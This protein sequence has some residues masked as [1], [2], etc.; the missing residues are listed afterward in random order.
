MKELKKKIIQV[1]NNTDITSHS[2]FG[3][4]VFKIVF[5]NNALIITPDDN[6]CVLSK[7]DKANDSH[8]FYLKIN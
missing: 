2:L 8:S 7:N 1:I 5:N 4:L 6:I 3:D